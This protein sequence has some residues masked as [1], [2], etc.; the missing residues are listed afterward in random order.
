MQEDAETAEALAALHKDQAD[1][2]RRMMDAELA[3]AAKR[4]RSDNIKIDIASFVAGGG[5]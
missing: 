1:A 2:V 5:A 4:I 3:T